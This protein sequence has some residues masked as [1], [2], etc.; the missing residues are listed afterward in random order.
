MN[1]LSALANLSSG[2]RMIVGTGNT[3]G[4][5]SWSIQG[6]EI[7]EYY[8]SV[9]AID[10]NYEGSAFSDD[11]LITINPTATFSMVDSVC[12]NEQAIVTYT[13]NASFT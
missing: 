8:T 4:N 2:Y 5:L 1:F 12:L 11:L 3:S 10:H 6:L 7:G 9:Q 13:G